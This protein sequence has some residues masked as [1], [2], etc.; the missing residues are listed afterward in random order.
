MTQRPGETPKRNG[1]YEERGPKGGKVPNARVITIETG[2]KKL[3]PT[4]KPN[5]R[6]VKLN[7]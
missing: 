6:W 7:K 2:D 3:P 1:E 5:R 4:Q